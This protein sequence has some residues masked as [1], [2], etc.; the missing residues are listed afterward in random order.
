MGSGGS[1][2]RVSEDGADC[3]VAVVEGTVDVEGD[4][5]L[6]VDFEGGAVDEDA[7]VGGVAVLALVEDADSAFEVGAASA[8]EPDDGVKPA[9]SPTTPS[10]SEIC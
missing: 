4:G 1:A 3:A 10:S 7:G 5:E 8:A 2:A 9:S 6:V